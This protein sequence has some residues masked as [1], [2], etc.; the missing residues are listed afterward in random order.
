VSPITL[1][2]GE[3]LTFGLLTLALAAMWL[4]PGKRALEAESWRR[5]FLP[6]MMALVAAVGCALYAQF[7]DWRGVLAIVAMGA[8]SW[9]AY[10]PRMSATVRLLS[11]AGVLVLA[12]GL[13]LHVVPGFDNPKILSG[14]VLSPDALPY[15]KYLNFDKAVTGLF[16]L[17]F[18]EQLISR[19]RE[20]VDMLR[21]TAPV[22]VG[23][24]GVVLVLSF[25]LGYVRF[26]PTPPPFLLFWSWT[27]LFFT[28]IAEEAIFRGFVQRGLERGLASYRFG[29]HTAL[30]SASVLFGLAH[31]A[32]GPRYILLATVAGIGYGLAM[33]K[34]GRIEG[35]IATH[36]FLN[37]LHYTFFTYPALA[38]VGG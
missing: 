13:S 2:F 15:S 25:A 28:C 17:A 26:Q 19:R 20:W 3:S 7:L 34:S 6:S 8:A 32:G 1:T 22:M 11:I 5:A 16:L 10:R 23:T 9:G 35:A 31:W 21:R 12:A 33:R 18:G 27:N 37:F 36:F 30:L 29:A 38:S 4:P 14:A 24:V